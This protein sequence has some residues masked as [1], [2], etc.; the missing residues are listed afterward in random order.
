MTALLPEKDK[1][2][3]YKIILNLVNENSRILDL[4]CGDGT[5]LDLLNKEKNVIGRGVEISTE[6]VHLSMEKGLSVVQGN[7][8]EGLSDYEDKSFD[9]VILSQTLQVIREPLLVI[10]EMLRVGK[11]VIVSFPNSGH[12]KFRFNLLLKGRMPKT[13]LLPFEWYNTPN[14][15]SLTIKDFK[16]FIYLE[17]MRVVKEYYF[18]DYSKLS[19][20]RPANFF[21]SMAMYVIEGMDNF[22]L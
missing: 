9:W 2:L 11:H 22:P 14:I 13:K 21:A 18:K 10:L 7:I 17:K 16:D 3:D 5:L 19:K 4:G 1:R 20:F 8:D 6:G 15:R 12:W